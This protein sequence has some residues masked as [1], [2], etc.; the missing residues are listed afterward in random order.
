[1]GNTSKRLKDTWDKLK[2]PN[3]LAAGVPVQEA[4]SNKNN[5]WKDD[6]LE[7]S[8]TAHTSDHWI[9]LTPRRTNTKK[10]T[11]IYIIKLLKI[12]EEKRYTTYKGTIKPIAD[13]STETT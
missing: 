8:K 1:M 3:I 5:T 10:I 2:R 11:F 12:P 6:G 9:P 4:K 7:F 13:F